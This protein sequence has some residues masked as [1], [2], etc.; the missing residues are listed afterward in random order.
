MNFYSENIRGN[1]LYNGNIKPMKNRYIVY[2]AQNF[3]VETARSLL[4]ISNYNLL[5]S[6]K[7]FNITS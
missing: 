5:R 2:P 1:V 3:A 6:R 7:H 4:D